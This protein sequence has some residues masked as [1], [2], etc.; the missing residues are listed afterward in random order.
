MSASRECSNRA[1]VKA[2]IHFQRPDRVPVSHAVLPA[3]LLKYGDRLA[4]ILTEFHDDFGWN[5]MPDLPPEEYPPIYRA[6]LH[7]DDFGTVWHAKWLGISGIPVEWPI[8]DLDRYY[9]YRWPN[10]FTVG[11]PKGRLYSGHMLGF[12]DRWYARGAWIT[13]FEQL[14]QLRGM[15]NLLMDIATESRPF[16]RLL[17]D[18]LAFNMRW[19]GEWTRLDYDGLHFADDWGSQRSLLINP[20]SWR[21][22]FKPIYAQMFKKTHDAGMDVWYHSDGHINDILGDVIEIGADV[23]N[24]QA[25]VIGHDWIARNVRGKVAFRTDIDRQHVLPFGTPAEVKEEVHRIF[26]S[27]GT[28]DGG[29]I[30]CG[31]LSPTVPL[32]NIRAMYEAFREYGTYE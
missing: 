11:P 4:E 30:A 25:R 18:M 7:A 15:E 17:D 9:Q 21:R 2:A 23:I 29:L 5:Y 14:Q 16:Y 28:P 12:D 24:C 1:R 8:P 27:S 10:G 13:V 31:E 22:L 19:I 6:G 26:E 20:K 3:A 32:E